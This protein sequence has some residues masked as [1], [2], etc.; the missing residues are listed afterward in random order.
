M[1]FGTGNQIIGMLVSLWYLFLTSI[2]TLVQRSL[3]RRFGYDRMT[4]GRSGDGVL[5]RMFRFGDTAHRWRSSRSRASASGSARR[6][7]QLL[8]QVGLGGRLD[9]YP[10]ELL[11]GQQQR[12]AIARALAMDPKLMLFDEPASA[13]D[14]ELVGEVLETMKSL[15]AGE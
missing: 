4:A 15:A 14:P 9:A 10:H 5:A 1:F 12:V 3:E 7:V 13:L 11:G 2:L 8:Q 6:G